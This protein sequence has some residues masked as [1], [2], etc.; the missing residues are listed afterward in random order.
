MTSPQTPEIKT[1][2]PNWAARVQ[3]AIAALAV[4]G[5]ALHV[6]LR[7][8]AGSA[9]TWQGLRVVD[10]PLIVVLVLGGVPLVLELLGNLLRREFGSDQAANVADLLVEELGARGVAGVVGASHSCMTVRGVRKPG[11]R[12]VTSAMKG[13]FRESVSS[14]SEVLALIYGGGPA[15]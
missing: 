9:E 13:I 11:S 10:L 8:A 3:I 6:V 1:D 2:A 15:S 5:I 14:R 7:L 4:L 12:C